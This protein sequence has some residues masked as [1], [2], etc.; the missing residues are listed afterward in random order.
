MSWNNRSALGGF[1][2]IAG[3]EA[4]QEERVCELALKAQGPVWPRIQPKSL[5]R[6]SVPSMSP[7][8]IVQLPVV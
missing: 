3:E 4:Q 1:A 5:D 7:L 6:P 2:H 8:R